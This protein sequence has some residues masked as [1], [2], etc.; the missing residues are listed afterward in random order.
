MRK[1]IPALESHQE[2]P[3]TISLEEELLVVDE[4]ARHEAQIQRDL[5]EV[6][7]GLDL[8]DALEDLAIV[9]GKIK[10][11][12]KEETELTELCGQMATAG[13]DVEPGE[14]IPSMESYRDQSIATESF[15]ERA[16]QIWETIQKYL[17]RVWDTIVNFF[18]RVF[19]QIP[20][21]KARLADLKKTLEGL[22]HGKAEVKADTHVGPFA[23]IGHRP[24]TDAAEYL[25]AND[26]FTKVGNWVF[27]EYAKYVLDMGAKARAGIA[28]FNAEDPGAAANKMRYDLAG[29]KLS[30]LPG[31]TAVRTTSQF[32]T[33]SSEELL[34]N[35]VLIVSD[36]KAADDTT[37]LGV[38]ER[39]RTNHVMVTDSMGGHHEA[40]EP[41]ELKPL[42]IDQMLTLVGELDAQL[43]AA[44]KFETSKGEGDLARVKKELAD[45][46]KKAEKSLS[47]LDHSE[48][49]GH[50]KVVETYYRAMLN[51]NA[52]FLNWINHPL[53]QFSSLTLTNVRHGITRV[54]E[55]LNCYV[56][57]AVAPAAHAMGQPLLPRQA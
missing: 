14:F 54:K 32:E 34:H 10:D 21:Y 36:F 43:D 6:N 53:L 35:K 15:T 38:L 9:A 56:G 50:A 57:E 41:K 24:V 4:C 26:Y 3:A 25:K 8:S 39:L 45:A 16:K 46:S 30:K 23:S 52:A 5:A 55:S 1:F 11:A 22:K 49:S 17:A 7:R 47:D 37:T 40:G 13:S 18:K 28:N 12:S 31:L 29:V 19:Q 44:E 20:R 33:A 51:F 27:G 48:T 2:A 42:T